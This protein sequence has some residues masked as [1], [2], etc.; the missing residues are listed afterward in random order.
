MQLVGQLA[1]C[2]GPV[3]LLAEVYYGPEY[4]VDV[5]FMHVEHAHAALAALAPF[6][7]QSNL[8]VSWSPPQCLAHAMR[9]SYVKLYPIQPKNAPSSGANSA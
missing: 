2:Y 4:V 6:Q 3:H 1:A 5:D 8:A 9:P 7:A